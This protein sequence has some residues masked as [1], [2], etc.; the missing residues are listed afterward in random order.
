[1][2]EVVPAGL[3]KSWDETT[4]PV[5]AV[6][7]PCYN[8]EHTIRQVV[9]DFRRTVPSAAVYVYDNNSHDRTK[10]IAADC[11][12]VV[13]SESMQGKGHVIR[14]MFADIEAD[15]YILV[16]G[17]DTY[18][19]ESA[20]VMLDMLL[21]ENVDMV[22]ACRTGGDVAAYRR[23]HRLGNLLLTRAVAF[24]FGNR[25][26]DI[27]SGYRVLS[28]RFV[29]SFPVFARGFEIETEITVHALTL[30]LPGKELDSRY[31]PRP[32][33]S[34]SKL[35]TYRDGFRIIR[36]IFHLVRDERPL[37]FFSWVAALLAAASI[38]LGYRVIA[39]FLRIGLVPHFPT[40]LLAAALGIL[41]ALSLTCGFVLDTVTRGR[42][43]M[44]MLAYLAT[45]LR[46]HTPAR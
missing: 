10:L 30:Q 40:A 8:E 25:F 9:A 27:L 24:L 28:R 36:V 7:I 29:K 22:V 45:P 6:L 2:A 26:K 33:G 5:I 17:D 38:A 12:A 20:P 13:G 1:M 11:G 39:E 41:S 34:V 46:R 18:D 3:R 35:R 31:R 32:K 21:S 37:F 16:D 14:R 42:R 44:A 15:A 19:A 23:G 43:S 4:P